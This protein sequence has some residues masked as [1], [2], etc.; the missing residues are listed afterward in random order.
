MNLLDEVIVVGYGTQKKSDLTGSISSVSSKDVKNYAVSNV[1]Q[2][3]TGK[4]AG[5]FVSSS[6]G[7]PGECA[8][9]RG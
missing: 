4:A 6:S 3:L 7:Q 8:F 1:S 5:V 9:G 2:L